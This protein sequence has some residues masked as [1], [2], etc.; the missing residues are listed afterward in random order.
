MTEYIDDIVD[1]LSSEIDDVTVR[2]AYSGENASR[3]VELPAMY[4]EAEAMSGGCLEICISIDVSAASGGEA[5]QTIAETVIN[6]LLGDDC[7]VT[8]ENLRLGGVEYIKQSM[9]FRV[10]VRAVANE[11]NKR[12]GFVAFNFS[13]DRTISVNST[14]KD[15]TLVRNFAQREIA[16][17]FTGMPVGVTDDVDYYDITLIG[18]DGD[19]I[20]TLSS[21]GVFALIIGSE[22]FY[23]CYCIQSSESS[24]RR[25]DLKI[26]AYRGEYVEYDGITP[27]VPVF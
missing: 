9:S 4:V 13:S 17:I 18:V 1:Y 16:E 25:A 22:R 24:S 10:K 14:V 12:C 15:Y 6:L 8:L 5:C 19:I 3:P 20:E 11:S 26:R 2:R 21:N 23:F 7:P 27:H